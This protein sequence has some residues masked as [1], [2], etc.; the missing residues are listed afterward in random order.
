MGAPPPA[1]SRLKCGGWSLGC[2]GSPQHP[3]P[4]ATPSSPPGVAYDHPITREIFSEV[5]NS[6][7]TSFCYYI[8]GPC[9]WRAP[10]LHA[11]SLQLLGLLVWGKDQVH[12]AWAGAQGLVDGRSLVLSDHG[13]G[14]HP[15]APG[16][17]ALAFSCLLTYRRCRQAA[18]GVIRLDLI[19]KEL[20]ESPGSL[21][22]ERSKAPALSGNSKLR[23]SA[24]KH[25]GKLGGDNVYSL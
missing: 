17:P 25:G 3:S 1:D 24:S 9:L 11:L 16:A 20:A 6:S 2:C 5:L 4:T 19:L 15:A 7:Q 18:P 14:D 22:L 12:A 21:L 13:A 10:G 8:C 23:F